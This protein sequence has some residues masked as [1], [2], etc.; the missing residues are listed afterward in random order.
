MQRKEYNEPIGRAAIP[1]FTVKLDRK[2]EPSELC[3]IFLGPLF[4]VIYLVVLILHGFFACLSLS[5]VAGSALAVNIPFNVTGL[6]EQCDN[7]DFLITFLPNNIPCR[8]AYWISLA[9]FAIVVVPLSLF[10]LK[11]QLIVQVTLGIMR[12]VTIGGV[13]VFSL[14]NFLVTDQKRCLMTCDDMWSEMKNDEEC[15][16]TSTKELATKFDGVSFLVAIP[17]FVFAHVCHQ[18]IPGLTHPVK[19]KRYLR[20]Y[21]N[22]LYLVSAIVYL[23]LGVSVSLWFRQCT[24]ETCTLNWVR[25]IMMMMMMIIK[26]S[27]VYVFLCRGR[28]H[29]VVMPRAELRRHTVIVLS[30]SQSV[31]QSVF[32]KYFSSLTEN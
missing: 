29:T 10:E 6:I 27:V 28:R 31:S 19:Q 9:A 7:N 5:T 14:A 4:K 24:V 3:E 20:A 21:L 13:I 15:N 26:L 23:L 11:E 30:V 1:N 22:A 12:F 18:C 2:F 25:T 16:V 17:V 32:Y 8:N